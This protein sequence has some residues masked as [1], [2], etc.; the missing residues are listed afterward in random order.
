[1]NVNDKITWDLSEQ[2]YMGGPTKYMYARTKENKIMTTFGG[3]LK[4]KEEIV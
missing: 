1:M 4:Q 2:A 3:N